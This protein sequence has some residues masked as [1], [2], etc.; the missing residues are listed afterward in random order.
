VPLA[1]QSGSQ[2]GAANKR[3]METPPAPTVGDDSDNGNGSDDNQPTPSHH[4][5]HHSSHS[6]HGGRRVAKPRGRPPSGGRAHHRPTP[7]VAP[8]TKR[9]RLVATAHELAV[10]GGPLP[11]YLMEIPTSP[12]EVTAD[13]NP[14][15]TPTPAG[16]SASGRKQR[17]TA[18]IRGAQHAAMTRAS[19][20]PDDDLPSPSDG[21][22][23]RGVGGVA[24][25][26]VVPKVRAP[27]APLLE[28]FKTGPLTAT[29]P[30][31]RPD[32][33]VTL[34]VSSLLN[35]RLVPK[36]AT[37]PVPVPIMGA[38]PTPLPGVVANAAAT[39]VS[40]P[41]AKVVTV[42]PG[43][44]NGSGVPVPVSQLPPSHAAMALVAPIVPVLPSPPGHIV[45]APTAAAA[46]APVSA[47][48]KQCLQSL[49][50]FNFQLNHMPH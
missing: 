43:I 42:A 13:M 29:Y 6:H 1:Q 30:D 39:T 21:G 28:V 16:V 20:N 5:S 18:G 8:T 38:V 24:V 44:I 25:G 11:S 34:K 31:G 32:R 37:P 22:N 4:H 17:S 15:M 12:H 7:V 10:T 46:A 23:A 47:P 14:N 35:R 50:I 36:V 49:L 33:K 2:R 9:A 45:S 3:K 27:P 40:R 48:V 19:H 26:G 41:P